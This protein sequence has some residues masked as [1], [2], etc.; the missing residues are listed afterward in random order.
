MID[1]PLADVSLEV[2]V[3]LPCLNEAETLRGC[4]NAA[5]RCLAG[6]G[7]RGEVIVADNGSTDGSREIAASAGARLV[8]VA[9]RGYGAALMSGCS[10]AN[11]KLI[12]FADADASY[13]FGELAKFVEAMRAGAELVM[14]TRFP[15][16]GGTIQPGAMPFLHRWLGTPVLTTLT[17]MFF[18]A[19]ITDVNCGMRGL[20]K[21][22]FERLDLQMTGMEFASEM[23]LKASLL[24]LRIS[25]VPIT[26]RRD[27][28]S[29]SSHLR[30]W[31]DGW[32][33][34]R[35]LLLFSPRWL[36]AAPG[37]ALLAAGI[38]GLVT[39]STGEVTIGA[40]TFSTNT[41]M[42][43]S[44]LVVLGTQLLLMGMFAKSFVV[45]EQLLP[46]SRLD[47]MASALRMESGIGVGL[48]TF[49]VGGGAIVWA[50]LLWQRNGFASLTDPAAPRLVVLG[51]TMM[52][53]GVQ[54]VSSAFL[55]GV[56]GLRRRR[57][58]I[59]GTP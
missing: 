45:A 57:R 16:G 46:R 48:A 37:F 56:L 29:R 52:V 27:G 23:V 4:I 34:L 1:A 47:R 28:R 35:V 25:E 8:A 55:L 26:L 18:G 54:I 58:E 2:S 36:F 41:M 21:D 53:I 19:A 59:V 15:R 6:A 30:T 20:R 17:R 42:V 50:A 10:A 31:R 3:V 33:H 44:M 22:A 32:R 39:L 7:I 14:G 40:V 38:I 5:T 51:V 43:A 24:G 49:V 9:E 12:V 13:D 11:G